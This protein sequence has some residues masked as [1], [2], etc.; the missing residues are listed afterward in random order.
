MSEVIGGAAEWLETHSGDN[1]SNCDTSYAD[2]TR[3]LFRMRVGGTCCDACYE[4]DTHAESG[5]DKI[6]SA[7]NIRAAVDQVLISIIVN[8]AAPGILRD[9]AKDL[10]SKLSTAQ[11]KAWLRKR[12]KD[13]SGN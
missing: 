1:C 8:G 6:L 4:T 3:R 7:Q 11:T 5:P 13:I 12:A 9:A 10:P 2:C